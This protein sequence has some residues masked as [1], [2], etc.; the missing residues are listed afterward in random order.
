MK[1]KKTK[2]L[3]ELK[4]YVCMFAEGMIETFKTW[5]A[6]NL[7]N[8]VYDGYFFAGHDLLWYLMIFTSGQI[9]INP[10]N[11]NVEEICDNI[12]DEKGR[13]TKLIVRDANGK[14][15]KTYEYEYDENGKI[16]KTTVRDG[17]GNII[18]VW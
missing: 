8:H 12:L 16:K 2:Y 17:E 18:D 3:D 13:T 5:D 4:H 11:G 10:A 7:M 15:Q 1:N 9:A 6:E 14:I